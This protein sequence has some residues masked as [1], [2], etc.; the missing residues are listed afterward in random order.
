MANKIL[1]C[2]RKYKQDVDGEL[3]KRFLFRIGFTCRGPEAWLKKYRH[4]GF[5]KCHVREVEIPKGR[6][7]EQCREE[8]LKL[9]AQQL[10]AFDV[11]VDKH[12]DSNYCYVISNRKPVNR[13]LNDIGY[14]L[15][16]PANEASNN[17]DNDLTGEVKEAASCLLM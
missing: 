17:N 11:T 8:L 10:E 7:V 13:L 14:K 1:V 15:P 4:E 12:G 6:N 5:R 9:I 3:R 2:T 16:L